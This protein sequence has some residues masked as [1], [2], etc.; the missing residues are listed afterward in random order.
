[1]TMRRSVEHIL[2][3]AYDGLV[4]QDEFGDIDGQPVQTFLGYA[5][6]PDGDGE[7]E[8]HFRLLDVNYTNYNLQ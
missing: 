3:D 1:L 6:E 7:V 5:C 2:N 8:E 4:R